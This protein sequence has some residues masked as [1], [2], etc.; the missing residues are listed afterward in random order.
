MGQISGQ[1]H[2]KKLHGS[3]R[4]SRTLLAQRIDTIMEEL[5]LLKQ[6]LSAEDG[7]EQL[8]TYLDESSLAYDK[9]IDARHR[10]TWVTEGLKAELRSSA[11]LLGNLTGG[12]FSAGERHPD[13]D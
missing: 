4:L 11:S 7:D 9:W 2:P 5:S 1:H 12:L 10:H 8:L 13:S 6:V 3:L